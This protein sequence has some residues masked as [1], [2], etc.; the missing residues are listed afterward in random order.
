MMPTAHMRASNTIQITSA[1]KIR[2]HNRLSN[3]SAEAEVVEDEQH[4]QEAE[5]EERHGQ[6]GQ[7]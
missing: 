6:H 2:S 5:E 3:G 1:T 7:P 4:R